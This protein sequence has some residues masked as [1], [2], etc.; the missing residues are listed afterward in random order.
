MYCMEYQVNLLRQSSKG[1]SWNIA[2]N[3]QVIPV[4]LIKI[5]K[6]FTANRH[7]NHKQ[8]MN[9]FTSILKVL[10]LVKKYKLSIRREKACNKLCTTGFSA[11]FWEIY[12]SNMTHYRVRFTEWVSS[13]ESV[14]TELLMSLVVCHITDMRM[15]CQSFSCCQ[16]LMIE[17]SVSLGRVMKITEKRDTVWLQSETKLM[18]SVWGG[19][20]KEKN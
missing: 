18:L 9:V 20:R 4:Y 16:S 14:W 3:I 1:S 15:L 7:E 12:I 2:N 19:E 5:W 8:Q 6:D 11:E 17:L 10:L 13:V